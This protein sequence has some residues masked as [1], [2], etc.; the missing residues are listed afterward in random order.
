MDR[1]SRK[2]IRLP[3]GAYRE[4]GSAWH[5]TLGTIDREARVFADRALAGAVVAAI[6][7]RCAAR[8][9][10]L[11]LCC[12]MPDHCHMVIQ[13]KTTG[14]IDV[15]GDVKSRTTRIWWTHGGAGPLW[16]R[17]FHDHGLR[18]ARDYEETVRYVLENPVRAGLVEDWADYPFIG[19]ALIGPPDG[20]TS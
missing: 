6:E 2:T 4:A 12:L 5:V 19:G 18:T 9:A 16:Q 8:D 17:S 11:D 10:G 7:E 20:E 15:M 13:I 1:P 3:A 14:L